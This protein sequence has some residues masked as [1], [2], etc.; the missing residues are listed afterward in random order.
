M[1]KCCRRARE[2]HFATTLRLRG[3]R[4]RRLRPRR[5]RPRRLRPRR[6]RP[7]RLRLRTLRPRGRARGRCAWDVGVG[8]AAYGSV[9][10]AAVKMR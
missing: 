2:Q 3:L 6:L 7:R 10:P 4:L 9:W 5:L 1:A 8:C